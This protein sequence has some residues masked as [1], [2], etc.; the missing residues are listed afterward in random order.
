M[1]LPL[2]LKSKPDYVDLDA[3]FKPLPKHGHLTQ[4]HEEYAL[5]QPAIDAMFDQVWAL[6]DFHEFRQVGLGVD[7]SMP[8][9][10]PDR[11][12]DVVTEF[13]QFPARD[14]H[15]IELKVYKSPKV[16]KEAA[17][18]LRMHGGGGFPLARLHPWSRNSN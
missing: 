11:A 12:R 3:D 4:P 5:V 14:G 1:P 15:M 9:G 8:P 18:M 7:A 13:L 6:P 2:I 17:L 16:Q 10:G